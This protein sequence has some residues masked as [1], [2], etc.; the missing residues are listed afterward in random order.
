MLDFL[1]FYDHKLQDKNSSTVV[2]RDEGIEILDLL[3]VTLC[4]TCFQVTQVR[5]ADVIC[6]T[7]DGSMLVLVHHARWLKHGEKSS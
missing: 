7:D 2:E 4:H 6:R 5:A 1:I 3:P